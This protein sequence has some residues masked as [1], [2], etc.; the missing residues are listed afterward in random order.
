MFS[1]KCRMSEKLEKDLKE[2]K[3]KYERLMKKESETTKNLEKQKIH[4]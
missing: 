1:R 3:F 4:L 2:L